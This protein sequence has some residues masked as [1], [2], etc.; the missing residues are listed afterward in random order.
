MMIRHQTTLGDSNVKFE[1]LTAMNTIS[2]VLFGVQAGGW[3]SA[4]RTNQFSPF[5]VTPVL[6]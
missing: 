4:F 1:V 5:K 2:A 3:S 6:S